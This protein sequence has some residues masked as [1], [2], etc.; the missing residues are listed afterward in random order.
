MK[1]ESHKFEQLFN[2]RKKMKTK[3]DYCRVHNGRNQEI[4]Y[5]YRRMRR[6]CQYTSL[7]DICNEIATLPASRFYISEERGK[8]ILLQYS[9]TGHV[10]CSS[11]YKRKL[12]GAFIKEV[13]AQRRAP[14]NV[15]V[16][17][18]LDKEAPCLGVSPSRIQN[19][20]SKM[21]AK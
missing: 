11:P 4:L 14:L 1:T 2:E 10:Y 5:H 20:L 13:M 12:Y 16:R 9:R 17:R 18:A 15:K 3:G 19:I 6:T 21:G 7:C 8:S